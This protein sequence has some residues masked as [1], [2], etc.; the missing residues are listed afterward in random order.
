MTKNCFRTIARNELT[1]V[2]ERG[3]R[4]WSTA[5]IMTPTWF[6]VEVRSQRLDTDE[7]RRWITTSIYDAI[8]IQE[9][10][11]PYMWAQIF[12]CLRAPFSLHAGTIFEVVTEAYVIPGSGTVVLH[13]ANGLMFQTHYV[14]AVTGA[15]KPA[16]QVKLLYNSRKN[17]SPLN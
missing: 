10:G 11:K 14:D 7:T 13:L 2:S 5:E 1:N 3:S 16:D 12:V 6:V 9:N 17:G 4:F 15:L 8:Q